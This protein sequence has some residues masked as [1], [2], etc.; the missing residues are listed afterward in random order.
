M[1]EVT[2]APVTLEGDARAALRSL[3]NRDFLQTQKYEK[4]RWSANREGAH[5]LIV[6]FAEALEK[7]MAYLGVPMYVHTMVRTKQEQRRLFEGGFTNHNGD[8]GFAHQ[9]CA[10]DL[11][12]G[13]YAWNMN[14]DQWAVIGHIGKEV[15]RLRGIDIKWGG[16]WK[17]PYDP[18]HWELAQ[19]RQRAMEVLK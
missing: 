15:A 3:V 8:H 10:I 12:H 19:W 1:Q 2:T 13:Q 6:E 4:Q 11:V 18:A 5:L 16:D 7:R 17:R 9:H 14:V